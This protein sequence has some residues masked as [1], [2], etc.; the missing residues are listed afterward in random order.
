MNIA[1]TMHFI[2]QNAS[3]SFVQISVLQYS[4]FLTIFQSCTLEI[5]VQGTLMKNI[6]KSASDFTVNVIQYKIIIILS[7]T[8]LI[9]SDS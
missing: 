4:S 9:F 2:L 7:A 6:I 3:L 5:T 1:Q 8:T